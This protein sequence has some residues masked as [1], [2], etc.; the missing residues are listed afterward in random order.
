VSMN[1]DENR[2]GHITVSS[3]LPFSAFLD[4]DSVS[5]LW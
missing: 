3:A 4:L 5:G 1:L 2:L